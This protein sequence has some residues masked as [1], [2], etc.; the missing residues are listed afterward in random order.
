M[1]VQFGFGGGLSRAVK[2]LLITNTIIFVVTALIQ[3]PLWTYLFGL[4]PYF[5]NH[6]F[7]LW[8]FF[9][10]MFLHGDLS[11]IGWNMFA[12]WMF[13]TEL[14]YNWGTRDF[15][16]YYLTCGVGG[17]I[18][19]WLTAFFDLS[20][21]TIPTIGASGAIFGILV[22]YGMMWPDRLILFFG[23]LPIKALH[24]VLI[25]GAID[26]FRG[27]SGTGGN[28]AVFAHVGGGITGFIYL[29]YGWRIMVYLESFFKHHGNLTEWFRRKRFTVIQGGKGKTDSDGDDD[30]SIHP[31]FD[32]EVDRILDKIARHGKDS[33]TEKER[34]LLD[35]AS[36]KRRQRK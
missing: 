13:G 8:Q 36:Q 2:A 32:E 4:T 14:E 15:I 25:F 5:I 28:I 23:I 30:Y 7:M 35:R 9:T 10:Y 18:L 19:V 27:I 6:K 31:D 24:F 20:A 22:A 1:P 26:L 33:L 29:K 34:K 16:K 3:S 12:L 17:G 11:H 21:A